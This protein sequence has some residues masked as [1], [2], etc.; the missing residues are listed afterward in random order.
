VFRNILV[1]IDGS[2][3]ATAALEEAI[4]LARRDG[5]RLTLITVAPPARWRYSGFLYVPYPS[6]EDLAR[7]ARTVVEHAETI[8]PAEIGVCSIV[9]VGNP[10]AA[11]VARAEEGGHDLIVMGTRGRGRLASL[12]LGSVSRAVAARSS[13]P[14]LIARRQRAD[15][16]REPDLRSPRALGASGSTA[17]VTTHTEPVT[18]GF[19]VLILWLVAALLLELQLALWILDRMYAP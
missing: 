3:S 10:A 5:A 16:L 14:V 19:P 18:S 4:D 12:L 7:S 11:I 8:V 15:S 9:R 13:V 6:E 1:A 2:P 17:A